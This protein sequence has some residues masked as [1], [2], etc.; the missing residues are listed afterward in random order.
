[1]YEPAFPF[2][3]HP[4]QVKEMILLARAALDIQERTYMVQSYVL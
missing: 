4:S 1:M 3:T 2:H